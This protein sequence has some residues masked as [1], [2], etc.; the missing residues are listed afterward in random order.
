MGDLNGDGLADLVLSDGAADAPGRPDAGQ[1]YIVFGTTVPFGPGAMDWDLAVKPADV[2]ITG[3][4]SSGRLQCPAVGDFTGDGKADLV[5][6]QGGPLEAVLWDG[7]ELAGAGAQVD[8]AVGIP[9]HSPVWSLA[10]LPYPLTMVKFG[11]F[12]GDGKM[13]VFFADGYGHVKG[14][15][16]G[17]PLLAGAIPI[18]PTTIDYATANFFDLGDINGDGKADLVLKE[19]DGSF[20][21]LYGYRPLSNPSVQVRG[22]SV[23]PKVVL[24]FSVDGEPMEM[25]L[26]GDFVDSVQD[27]WIPYQVSLPLTLTQ[28]EGPKTV[29]VVFRNAFE[30]E[31]LEAQATFTLNPGT[32]GLNVVDNVI[33]SSNGSARVDCHVDAPTHVKAIIRD[34]SGATI[35][36]LLD[37][38]SRLE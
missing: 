13:D 32:S 35:A 14:G 16:S 38:A 26:A 11:D 25:K 24:D 37:A 29:R 3:S 6:T 34:Q 7:G 4:R 18:L 27:R 33:D 23:P 15:L 21:I 30:R 8:L 12:D 22:G 28:T 9:G 17:T 19:M 1:V 10:G 20:G 5:F 36:G 31:S 2:T